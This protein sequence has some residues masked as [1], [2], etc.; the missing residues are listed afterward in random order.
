MLIHKKMHILYSIYTIHNK[1]FFDSKK[2]GTLQYPTP[3]VSMMVDIRT[4]DKT[5]FK[6]RLYSTVNYVTD[7]WAGVKSKVYRLK[8]L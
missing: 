4:L 3:T 7:F 8:R 2:S 5:T 6:I 1:I